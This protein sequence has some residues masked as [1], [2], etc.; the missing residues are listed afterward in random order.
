[1]GNNSGSAEFAT[2]A[3]TA[4]SKTVSGLPCDGRNLCATL[5]TYFTGA[6]DWQ[7]PPQVSPYFQLHG[8][9]DESAGSCHSYDDGPQHCVPET[10]SSSA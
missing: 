4:T 1:V 3:T 8:C 9:A 10:K 2:G 5:Y 6:V 7:R